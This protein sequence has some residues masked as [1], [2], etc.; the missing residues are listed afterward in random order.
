VSTYCYNPDTLL[1]NKK[2]K[3]TESHLQQSALIYLTN[4]YGL[5]HHNPRLMMFSIP[6]EAAMLLRSVLLSI[7]LSKSIVDK[8]TALAVKMMR[9]IG[10]TPGV[11]DTVVLLPN[12]VTLYVEFKTK[13]GVQ[14]SDQK[15]FQSRCESLG[16]K[17]YLVRSLDQF[18]SI[19]AAE[20]QKH[21]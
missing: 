6:N 12:G 5:K 4:T 14:S 2:M 16:H 21:T 13:D 18:K 1:N 19:I 9:N 11:S 8:A 15:E 3:E 17:Y 10:F 7:G 20:L